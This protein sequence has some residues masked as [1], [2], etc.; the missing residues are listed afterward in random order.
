MSG[1]PISSRHRLQDV[2]TRAHL[3][4][5]C[6]SVRAEGKLRIQYHAKNFRIFDERDEAVAEED[7]GMMI[8]LVRVG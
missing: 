5:L 3:I 7:L 8:V 2:H 4:D 1:A 6:L